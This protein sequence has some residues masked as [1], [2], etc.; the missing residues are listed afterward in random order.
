MG[1]TF[2][3]IG[4]GDTHQAGLSMEIGL[5]AL[6]F[7]VYRVARRETVEPIG[8]RDFVRPICRD[9]MGKGQA[10]G[11]RRL[12]AAVAPAAVEVEPVDRRVVDDR[13][14]VHRH[15][16]DAAPAPE[17]ACA[18]EHRHDGHAALANVLNRG[19]ISA[20]GIAVV[21]VDIAAEDKPTLVR[22]ADIE[23][24]CTKSYH[25]RDYG[26]QRF[27]NERLENKTSMPHPQTS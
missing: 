14:A 19:K 7:F 24:T 23:M 3:E 6:P 10:R 26:F 15:I 20:A 4:E 13:R 22:L 25:A 27:G 8:C 12:E 21:A 2:T 1:V 9:K 17:Q 18:P 16:R 11:G 5:G